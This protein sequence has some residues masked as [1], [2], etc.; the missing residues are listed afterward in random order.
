MGWQ[1]ALAG[2]QGNLVAIS[3]QSPDFLAGVRGWQLTRAGHL[4]ANDVTVRGDVLVQAA[5]LPPLA[6]FLDGELHAVYPN[7]SNLAVMSLDAA[8]TIGGTPV[9]WLLD[10]YHGWISTTA[11]VILGDAYHPA[12]SGQLAI[13]APSGDTT[14]AAD[15]GAVNAALALGWAVQ[16]L[17]GDYYINAPVVLPSH[18]P[19]LGT[20][21]GRSSLMGSR[22]HLASGFAG[23]A[24]IM[25][26]TGTS[27]TSATDG[28]LIDGLVLDGSAVASPAVH[29]IYCAGLAHGVEIRHVE[30]TG[31]SGD[32]LHT[33]IASGVVSYSWRLIDVE[34]GHNAGYGFFTRNMTDTDW[35][36]C[37]AVFNGLD[38][39]ASDPA[40]SPGANSQWIGCKA[41]ENRN[42]W[43]LQGTGSMFAHTLSGCST[44]S[45]DRNGLLIATGGA[46][47]GVIQVVG[48]RLW[49]DGVNGGAGGGGY[50]GINC[51]GTTLGSVGLMITGT[52]VLTT[53]VATPVVPQYGLSLTGL[54]GHARV[55]G[56]LLIGDTAPYHDGGGNTS[57]VIDTTTGQATGKMSALAWTVP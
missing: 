43:S 2:G 41:E 47:S 25:P 37:R 18:V 48:C 20:A 27:L 45:N 6:G 5:N 40:D 39:F 26:V 28:Y 38:G 53:N 8:E 32:G 9:A 46:T 30:I 50:A 4:E 13:I 15:A 55:S 49:E 16:L 11:A 29:G 35:L 10:P 22:I 42:G 23:T 54:T 34:A 52:E 21:N 31:F 24:A 14:G 12:A 7:S 51:T 1:H 3:F 33:A 36:Y 19:L 17:P 56:S 57:V 44:Q